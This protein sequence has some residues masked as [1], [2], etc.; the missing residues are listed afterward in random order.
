VD[1][2]APMVVGGVSDLTAIV[3]ASLASTIRNEEAERDERQ[4]ERHMNQMFMIGILSAMNPAAAA[5][6]QPIQN[7]L[8]QQMQIM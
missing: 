2:E 8:L 5:A 7:Q 1:V 4:Q 6:M 3:L